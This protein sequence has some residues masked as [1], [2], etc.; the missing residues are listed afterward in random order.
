VPLEVHNESFHY[1]YNSAFWVQHRVRDSRVIEAYSTET[2]I[3]DY[4]V[5]LSIYQTCEYRGIDFLQFLRSGE[6]RVDDYVHQSSR[7]RLQ[8]PSRIRSGEHFW[9]DPTR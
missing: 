5:L 3:R 2:G 6:K 7:P 8:E 4:L 9:S 1:G